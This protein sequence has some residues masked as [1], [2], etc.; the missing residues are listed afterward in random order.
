MKRIVLGVIIAVLLVGS[1]GINK[2]VRSSRTNVI[3]IRPGG[4]EVI[5]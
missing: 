3:R 4:R 1:A 5:Q 2:A